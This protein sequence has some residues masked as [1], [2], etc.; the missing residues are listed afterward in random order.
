MES[1][2]RS[3]AKPTIRGESR[4][5]TLVTLASKVA[6]RVRKTT[7]IFQTGFLAVP[8]RHSGNGLVLLVNILN[9]PF[10]RQGVVR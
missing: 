10:R 8:Q 4:S 6:T 3:V 1:T 9:A 5:Q 7:Y 2:T